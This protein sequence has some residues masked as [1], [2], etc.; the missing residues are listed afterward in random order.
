VHRRYANLLGNAGRSD[1]GAADGGSGTCQLSRHNQQKF[2]PVSVLFFFCF[3][4]FLFLQA[5]N[6]HPE[7]GG[8]S[9][10]A[11]PHVILIGMRGAGK[12]TM[13]RE[14]ARRM[15][16]SF[17]DLDEMAVQSLGMPIGDYVKAN[18]W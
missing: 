16:R 14:L 6:S 10:A 13:G 12:T 8:D 11:S 17:D 1:W 2:W 3:G 15:K 18:G 7:E 9:R 5:A 4:L